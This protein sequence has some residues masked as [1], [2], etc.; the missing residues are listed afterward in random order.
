MGGVLQ[1]CEL[2]FNTL[3]TGVGI[4]PMQILA[5][6]GACLAMPATVDSSDHSF[7]CGADLHVCLA[8]YYG[9]AIGLAGS[10][11]MVRVR[12]GAEYTC[13]S[14]TYTLSVYFLW[15]SSN[16]VCWHPCPQP[17]LQFSFYILL[18]FEPRRKKSS[19]QGSEYALRNHSWRGRR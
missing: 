18:I 12:V 16:F 3:E 8:L 6:G 1:A 17:S 4:F 7:R 2:L 14:I 11:A 10:R 9:V 15:T 13:M 19:I 5:E